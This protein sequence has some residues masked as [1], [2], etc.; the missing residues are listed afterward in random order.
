MEE[1]LDWWVC[2]VALAYL[3]FYALGHTIWERTF[4]EKTRVQIESAC[5][6]MG[7][8][9][10]CRARRRVMAHQVAPDKVEA[11]PADLA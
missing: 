11:L 1:R 2:G 6:R 9:L 3:C 8:R 5:T 7:R 10:P 4:P